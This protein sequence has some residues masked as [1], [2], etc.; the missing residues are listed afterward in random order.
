MRHLFPNIPVIPTGDAALDALFPQLADGFANSSTAADRDQARK[1]VR[2]AE[3]L[4]ES[5][6]AAAVLVNL[7]AADPACECHIMLVRV[8]GRGGRGVFLWIQLVRVRWIS[9]SI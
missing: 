2:R 3:A 9:T 6:D 8:G 7:Q 4:L 5:Q 1:R